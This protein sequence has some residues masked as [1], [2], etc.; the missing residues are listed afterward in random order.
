ML[1]KKYNFAQVK[2]MRKQC[3]NSNSHA[4]FLFPSFKNNVIIRSRE[5]KFIFE[6]QKLEENLTRYKKNGK[7]SMWIGISILVPHRF[8]K[9]LSL[10]KYVALW[11]IHQICKTWCHD[12]KKLKNS[13]TS[14]NSH[15]I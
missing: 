14:T 3:A 9:V 13:K 1:D 2:L 12:K 10:R 15:E 5:D 4:L 6:S 7:K 11:Q 8:H